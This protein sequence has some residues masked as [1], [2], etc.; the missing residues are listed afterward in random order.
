[1]SGE[2]Q[3]TVHVVLKTAWTDNGKYSEKVVT[4]A[5]V[6]DDRTDAREYAA[7]MNLRTKKYV[8][9]VSSCKMG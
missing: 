2:K 8:Y 3:E 9:K 1:M 6:F 4:A 5:K 7:R